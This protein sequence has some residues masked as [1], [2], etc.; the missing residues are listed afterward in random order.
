MNIQFDFS[1]SAAVITGAAGGIAKGVAQA[2]AAAGAKLVIGDIKENDGRATVQELRD[3]GADAV[4]VKTDVT[5]QQSTDAL[6]GEALE[7]FGKLDILVN[8]AGSAGRFIGNPITRTDDSDFESTYRVNVM[9]IYHTMKSCYDHFSGRREGKIIN[10][11]SVV[12]HSTNPA[13]PHYAAS[14]A[15]A[16]NLTLT[17]AKELGPHNVKVNTICPGYIYTPMYENAVDGIQTVYP[18]FTGLTGEQMVEQFAKANCCLGRPQTVED[19]AKGV[20]YLASD[21]GDN[22]T[23]IVLDVAGGYKL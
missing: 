2:F 20:L 14:K 9:G 19:L 3:L 4:F 15:A 12:G 17:L 1:G 5:S 11:T 8:G 18:S 21:A 10:I 7:R 22:I 13:I 23:G 6:I 16:I